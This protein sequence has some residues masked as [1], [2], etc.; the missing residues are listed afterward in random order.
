MVIVMIIVLV[1][2]SLCVV[3]NDFFVMNRFVSLCS[4]LSV[5]GGRVVRNGRC[6]IVFCYSGL[7]IGWLCSVWLWWWLLN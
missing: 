7:G 2:L 5:L 1:S 3:E 4:C 6:L